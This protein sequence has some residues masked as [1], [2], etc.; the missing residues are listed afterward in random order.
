M[1]QSTNPKQSRSPLL[2]HLWGDC[3]AVM[4]QV[5]RCGQ[6]SLERACR[7]T[8]LWLSEPPSAFLAGKNAKNRGG[9]GSE[10]RMTQEFLWRED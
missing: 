6:F 3:N 10:R 8:K 9:V 5:L 1:N 2:K 7:E 4:A